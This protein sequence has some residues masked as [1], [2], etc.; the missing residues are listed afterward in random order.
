VRRLVGTGR[1]GRAAAVLVGGD[2][3]KLDVKELAHAF[4]LT[5]PDEVSVGSVAGPALARR[6]ADML[7]SHD[8]VLARTW[9]MFVPE[10]A[11]VGLLT[12]PH[13][14]ELRL[15][16]GPVESM[17]AAANQ[18]TRRRVRRCDDQGYR[19]EVSAGSERFDE[20]YHNY[21]LPFVRRRH[22]VD[23][24]E[25]PPEMLRRRLRAGPGWMA[26]ACSR[27]PSRSLER[28]FGS[29]SPARPR[30]A[31]TVS[32]SALATPPVQVTF[33]CRPS[34]GCAG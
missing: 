25:H 7:D 10:A 19:L 33:G 18:E 17:L 3:S 14:P 8:L 6:L 34:V 27:S 21:H 4:F 9:N 13:L 11:A 20:F 30:A 32:S 16:V 29:L 31:R 5:P 1:N 22:G 2:V 28:R 12:L 23:S 24:V 15:A 26:S